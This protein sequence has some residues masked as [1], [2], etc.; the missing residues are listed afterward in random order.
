MF[1]T[2]CKK[3]LGVREEMYSSKD[4][5]PVVVAGFL[6]TG[7]AGAGNGCNRYS[8]RMSLLPTINLHK[9]YHQ[10]LGRNAIQRK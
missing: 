9:F 10:T 8:P 1:Y 5:Y 7:L 3:A 4:T 2:A 6:R